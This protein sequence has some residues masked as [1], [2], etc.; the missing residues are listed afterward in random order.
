MGRILPKGR[1]AGP[2]VLPKSGTPRKSDLYQDWWNR[3]LLANP[4]SPGSRGP[5]RSTESDIPTV[6]AHRVRPTLKLVDPGLFPPIVPSASGNRATRR[7]SLLD[8]PQ[9]GANVAGKKLLKRIHVSDDAAPYNFR[10]SGSVG[11]AIRLKR[12]LELPNLVWTDPLLNDL[13][14]FWLLEIELEQRKLVVIHA[15]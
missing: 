1:D 3:S 4:V 15:S 10:L 6:K 12:S 8:S 7:S 2:G 9:Y 13:V 5:K 11:E 14:R